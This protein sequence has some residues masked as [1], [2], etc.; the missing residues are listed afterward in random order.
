ME[1]KYLT[2]IHHLTIRFACK[3]DIPL[4]LEFI[5][6]LAVYEKLEHEVTVDIS[7]LKE[8]LFGTRNVAEV[9]FAEY[10]DTPVAFSLFFHNF[11][12]F[13]GKPG[14]YIE[15]LF[16]DDN[17]RGKGIGR[18]MLIF[19]AW[20]ALERDCGRLEWWVLDWNE[21]A[22]NF[23]HTLGAQAMDDWTVF[24]ITGDNLVQLAQEYKK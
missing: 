12:T 7:V 22:I 4:I 15:D 18:E 6:K 10:K 1:E 16:V 14:L 8:S 3:D 21:P 13:L 23:Y 11:S 5:K 2:N 17:M 9:I 24:R 20:L 19:L